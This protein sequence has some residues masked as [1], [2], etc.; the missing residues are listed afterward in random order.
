[1]K[2]TI[3]TIVLATLC[4]FFSVA[5]VHSQTRALKIGDRVPDITV[6][7][8]INHT[9]STL[10]LSDYKGKLLILD[11]WATWCGS[12]LKSI[13]LT[14]SLQK[15]FGGKVEF[16]SV[17]YQTD[18]EV[19]VYL[20]KLEK[21][22]PNLE[23]RKHVRIVE[24]KVLRLLF[25]HTG[26]PHYVWINADGIVSAIT[27]YQ[28]LTVPNISRVVEEGKITTIVKKDDPR[29]PHNKNIP[30]LSNLNGN[31]PPILAHS[32]VSGYVPGFAGGM[33]ILPASET[34]SR[35]IL[36]RNSPLSNHY[37]TAYGAG[38]KWFGDAS[39]ALEVKDPS[40]LDYVKDGDFNSWIRRNGYCYELQL[41]RALDSILFLRMQ[42][43]LATSF[44]Q[45]EAFVEKRMKKVLAL[46]RT[47]AADKIAS[48]G[49]T[50]AFRFTGLQASMKNTGI[51]M[52]TSQLSVLF[53]QFLPMPIVNDT[54]YRGKVDLELNADLSDVNSINSELK[55][56]DL[57]LVEKDKEVEVLV[58]RDKPGF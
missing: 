25:P 11:F 35:K 3:K 39:I 48:Q 46:V 15:A 18:K 16:L 8:A 4:H 14:D 17:T 10:K 41:P 19:D 55:K 34:H 51:N 7:K 58:I 9:G 12:C 6:G 31:V 32:L 54:G 13:P 50:P 23:A 37:R 1:M 53:L 2:K 36:V 26:L 30:I 5:A 49:G 42:N 43:D 47:S 33:D 45:Y 28:A 21:L 44:P 56:Y 52:L 27:D 57:R 20:A 29:I 22:K 40:R 24:D 38:K